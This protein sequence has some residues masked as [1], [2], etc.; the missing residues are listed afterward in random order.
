[1][2]TNWNCCQFVRNQEMLFSC[3]FTFLFWYPVFRSTQVVG[4]LCHEYFFLRL[5]I[6]LFEA[7][8]S[9]YVILK[10]CCKFAFHVFV[11][12]FSVWNSTDT[13]K[14][15]VPTMWFASLAFETA[16]PQFITWCINL[17]F[18]TLYPQIVHWCCGN[19]FMMRQTLASLRKD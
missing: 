10:K 6:R 16:L 17:L 15:C 8:C 7:L 13:N 2:F 19:W 9:T 18:F 14:L 3:L 12:V 1:M 11:L 5:N 4:P